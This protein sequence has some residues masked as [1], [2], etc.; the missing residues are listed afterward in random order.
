MKRAI[1]K[2]SNLY[3]YLEPFLENGSEEEIALARKQ[4]WKE[5]KRQWR[6][7]KRA[8]ETELRVSFTPA[9][10]K[11][12]TEAAR[13]HKMSRT[14]YI[15]RTTMAYGHKTFVVPEYPE[16]R[17]IAQVLALSY[18]SIAA[19]LDENEL[20]IGIGKRLLD[21]ISDLE[22]AILPV[23]HHPAL[24]KD[25]IIHAVRGKPERKAELYQLLETIK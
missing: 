20:P 3:Q 15:K 18:N 14:K 21:Q 11:V 23:L 24:L 22:R 5:Y 10:L 9:E 7:A 1:K 8:T 17:K 25:A 12:L 4:Y 6:K 2:R 16:I 13:K 19:L